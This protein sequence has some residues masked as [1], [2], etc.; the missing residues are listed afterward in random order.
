MVSPNARAVAGNSCLLKMGWLS[1]ETL[2]QKAKGKGQDA[3]G[4]VLVLPPCVS[5]C[6]WM[7]SFSTGL[8]GMWTSISE[9][10]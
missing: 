5:M 10:G 4:L 8:R 6:P 9:L 1:I 3:W 2:I 7:C